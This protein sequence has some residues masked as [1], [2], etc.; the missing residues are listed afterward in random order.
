[1]RIGIRQK[2]QLESVHF[3][4]ESLYVNLYVCRV[5]RSGTIRGDEG[6]GWG[7]GVQVD[8]TRSGIGRKREIYQN[9]QF[10]HKIP[11]CNFD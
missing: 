2:V 6:R 4:L 10:Y 7:P 1:M 11:N 8:N 5:G 9:L 3:D